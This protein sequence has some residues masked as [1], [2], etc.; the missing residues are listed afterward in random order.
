MNLKGEHW[1]RH[2]IVVHPNKKTEPDEFGITLKTNHYSSHT[3]KIF[4]YP[5]W[6]SRKWEWYIN[7]WFAKMQLRFPRH[8]LSLCV[9]GYFPEAEANS[10]AIL[11]RQISAAKAQVSKVLNVMEMRRK[12]LQSQLFQDE[13]S[14]PLMSECRIK[15]EEKKY[16]LQLLINNV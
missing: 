15:L 13:F 8:H 3:L 16:K 6:I 2:R 11:K 10:E 9:A 4:D 12:E 5:S 14:D 7:Y 1:L